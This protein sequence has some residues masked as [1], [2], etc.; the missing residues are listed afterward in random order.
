MLVSALVLT[1]IYDDMFV[2]VATRRNKDGSAVRYVQL[3]QNEWDPA[4]RSSRMRVVHSFGRED[5]L[6]RA[7]VERLAMSLG[8]LLGQGERTAG[9]APELAYAGSVAFGGTYLLDQLW[10]QLG[11]GQVMTAMLGRTRRDAATERVLFALV[12]NR[13]LAPSSKLAAAHWA[14]R[15]AHIDQLPAT[16]DDACYRAM[17][18]LHQARDALERQVFGQVAA[19]LNL[20]VDLLFFDTTSTYFEVDDEDEPVLRDQ[21]GSPVPAD[22]AGG[23]GDGQDMTGFRVFGK[24][25]DHRDDLPQIVIGLAVTRTGI[26]V[27]IWCWPGNTA[28]S[29]LIRQVKRDMRDWTLAKIVWVADRGFTSQANRRY[30][31][32]G[33]HHYIIG[34]KLRSGSAEAAAALSRQGRYQEITGNLRVKEVR[35]SDDER[36]VI[37]HNPEA[38]ERDAATRARMLARLKEMIEGTDTLSAT[39]R[40]EL[41]GVIS[42]KPGLNRYLRVT[43]GGLLRIDARAVRAEE[44]LDG[45][46]LLRASDP[47][48]PAADI[49]A[50]YKQLLEVERGWR[51]I[52]QVIDL[53]PVYHRLEQRIRAHVILC[54]LALLLIRIAET[55]AGTTWNNICDELSQL[56]LGTFT[57]PAGTFR[58]TAE[59]TQPQRDI[60]DSL[61]IPYPKKIIQ[62]A[63]ATPANPGENRA[64]A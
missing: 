53:R 52:K 15:T 7:A 34:E 51:D 8:R 20:E 4:A 21:D 43:P 32:R 47:K 11:I 24:S 10:Q 45:K 37:C 42:T 9:A 39:R 30:L 18:W 29:V 25:K 28:D 54:W 50:G 33:D 56:T 46:Y 55:A 17:D 3:V 19:A 12:A 48:L 40:A 41:R 13:A 2:R 57:G 62:A 1:V 61:Q 5:Q 35:I 38:A 64:S 60:L 49:A 59:L 63:P 14:G 27:R 22:A 26:P 44:N 36:F 58:Q 23:G 16:T 6:D 31:R